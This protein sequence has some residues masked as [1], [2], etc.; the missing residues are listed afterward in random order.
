MAS[1]ADAGQDKSSIISALVSQMKAGSISKNDL[2][3]QLSK[4]HRGGS[5]VSGAPTEDVIT[6]QTTIEEE[7][8]VLDQTP[9]PEGPSAEE[10][11]R[12][13]VEEKRRE[14]MQASNRPTEQDTKQQQ[15]QQQQREQITIDELMSQ[16]SKGPASSSN[17]QGRGYATPRSARSNNSRRSNTGGSRRMQDSV[18]SKASRHEIRENELKNEAMAECT[19]APKITKLP[20]SYGAART[21][22]KEDFHSRVMKWKETKEKSLAQRREDNVMEEMDSC[23]FKPQVNSQNFRSHR[24]MTQSTPGRSS[25]SK[26]S[27][28]KHNK[29]VVE[30]LYSTQRKATR[31]AEAELKRKREEEFQRTCTFQPNVAAGSKN[32]NSKRSMTPFR[33][34]QSQRK[35]NGGGYASASRGRRSN[36]PK[37]QPT[38]KYN[39]KSEGEL[40]SRMESTVVVDLYSS[41]QTCFIVQV[42]FLTYNKYI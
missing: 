22:V 42:H 28:R 19:F 1:M 30:R 6:P 35:R 5:T 40:A 11:V 8:D 18:A 4:L 37:A 24:G 12:R 31:S 26:E 29:D 20:A 21:Y 3:E 39:T 34:Q 27:T 36:T 2:F 23:T 7:D 33:Y 16:G 10:S 15:P 41:L 25:N 32:R 13:L 14:R 9:S 17:H 38:G